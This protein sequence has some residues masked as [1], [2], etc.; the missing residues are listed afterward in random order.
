[1]ASQEISKELNQLDQKVSP[2]RSKMDEIMKATKEAMPAIVSAW[3]QNEVEQQVKENSKLVEEWNIEKMKELKTKVKELTDSL[4]TIIES[5][6]GD[7]ENW[8]HHK[9]VVWDSSPTFGPINT[10]YI[11]SIF[12]R[13]LSRLGN[14]LNEFDF[15][16]FTG[17]YPRWRKDVNGFSVSGNLGLDK[18]PELKT[19]EYASL[20]G[21]YKSLG[22]K[23]RNYQQR[24]SEAKAK[25]M[26]DEA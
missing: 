2:L 17:R 20:Y 11:D 13:V 16:N 12:R 19:G 24:L 4:P 7:I 18:I 8:P 15:F 6:F 21:E 10:G 26:W 25:E 9:E 5:E 23:I 14:I 3:M 1:M 22:N